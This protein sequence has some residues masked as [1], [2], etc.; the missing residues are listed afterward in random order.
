M[1]E[2]LINKLAEV[3]GTPVEVLLQQLQ[4]AGISASSAEDSITDREKLKLLEYIRASK[5]ASTGQ[6]KDK[7]KLSLKKRSNS[8]LNVSGRTVNVAV[9][10]KKTFIRPTPPALT[11]EASQAPTEEEDV[12]A[13][14]S[15]SEELA[16]T[17]ENER[18]AREQ[19]TIDRK[20]KQ[21]AKEATKKDSSQDKKDQTKAK[22]VS[23]K[24]IESDT[25]APKETKP[26]KS[27]VEEKI[28]KTNTVKTDTDE[29]SS[30]N[31][32]EARKPVE[33]NKETAQKSTPE[34][35]SAK[36]NL[37]EKREDNAGAKPARK[38]VAEQKIASKEE[39]KE[40]IKPTPSEVAAATANPTTAAPL[41]PKEMRE[42]V[43][44][45]AKAEAALSLKRRPSR[46]PPPRPVATK[47]ATAEPT[48]TPKTVATPKPAT[49]AK[50]VKKKPFQ[51]RTQGPGGKPLHI[52]GGRRRNKRGRQRQPVIEQSTEHG[53]ERPTA[54]VI[55]NVE[56]PDTI[57][58]SELASKLAVKGADIIRVLM[59]MGVMATINQVIDQ[60]TAI[61]IVEEMG[62]TAKSVK[63]KDEEVS[64]VDL[65]ENTDDFEQKQRPPVVTIMGH[66]DHG[67]T[68]LL[69]YIRQSRVAAGE[70]GGITQHIDAYHVETDNGVISFLD[71]PGH[72]AFSDMRARG[73]KATDIVI[74]VVAA[75]DGVMPQTEEAIKHTRKSGVPLIIA[76]NKIDKEQANPDQV[77]NDLAN[78][79][80]VPED[81]GGDDVFVNISAKTGEGIDELLEAILLVSE[82]L[83]LKARTEG[84]ATGLIIESRVEKGR[85]AVA[86]V[87]VQAGTLKKG[88][89]VLCG[90][91]YG[92][93]RAML[94]ED[95]KMINEATPSIPVEIQGL[96]GTP[97]SGSELVVLKR[98]RQARE[99]A[100]QRHEKERETHFAAQQAAKLDEMFEKM[101]PG[102]KAI[103]NILLKADVH[104]SMEAIMQSLNQLS[105]SEVAVNIIAASIGG[106]TETDVARAQSAEA[107]IMGF[108]VRADATAR[109]LA[110][111]T[112][113]ETRYYSIIYELIDDV[114][115]AMSG[116]LKPELREELI[117]VAEV[118][119]T[120]RGTGFGKIAGCLVIEGKIKSGEPIRVLRDNVVIHE[121]ELDSLRRHQDNV[122]EVK[123]GTE[124]GIGV[125]KYD[126]VQ[127]GDQIEV[128]HRYEV[129][130]TLERKT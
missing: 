83:E 89:I 103:F 86:S 126:D 15:R 34:K 82:V 122:N 124:C 43:A 12:V 130:R 7:S 91:E 107:V 104:G 129:Q 93:I 40:S 24:P 6:A 9:K 35:P 112:G 33:K 11:E 42:I 2:I 64:S 121:G 115:D 5:V 27:A 114:H 57:V 51:G 18:K 98:E 77:K 28:V 101:K 16:K 96:S 92:R 76:I 105:T 73:A 128:F 46:K 70:A 95:G 69:D 88:D 116:L 65:Q 97:S 113:V 48:T 3:I 1:S 59:G 111:E 87:L 54:P 37:A 100:K 13:P 94:D 56:I 49:P 78:Y 50:K 106:I 80:V 79:E 123:V 38:V 21:S 99:I 118:K 61:L 67:K 62:H 75:D 36:P 110:S 108:N 32:M 60:D 52:K 102:D 68:S 53:F 120:F 29:T 4:D 44:K 119:D 26:V 45:K 30:K 47:K 20:Q 31:K 63:A 10:R 14:S 71:T 81:W 74:V 117:G 58:V 85:G 90:S 127:A 72:A 23:E 25:T 8:A 41:S 17:L 39:I 109:R 125:K 22:K 66:V 84:P 19:A 55:R